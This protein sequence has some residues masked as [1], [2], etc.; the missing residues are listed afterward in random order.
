MINTPEYK[1]AKFLDSIIKQ[2]VPNSYMVQSTD[3]FLT[4]LKDFDFD[5]NQ[6]LVSYDVKSLF[7]NIPLFHTINIIANYIYS[8]HHNKHPPIK[9]NIFNKLMHLPTQGMFLYNKL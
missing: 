1:I 6:F 2:H 5:S 8:P 3:D 4:K 7:T 9:K